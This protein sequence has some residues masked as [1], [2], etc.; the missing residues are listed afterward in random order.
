MIIFHPASE[1]EAD[2]GLIYQSDFYKFLVVGQSSGSLDPQ[3]NCP[4]ESGRN[5]EDRTAAPRAP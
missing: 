2:V 3:V 5:P 4:D 1:G